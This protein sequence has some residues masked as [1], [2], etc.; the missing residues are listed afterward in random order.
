VSLGHGRPEYGG[1]GEG[2]GRGRWGKPLGTHQGSI[3]VLGW[4]WG[5]AGIGVLRRGRVAAARSSAPARWQLRGS[6]EQ[7]GEL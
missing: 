3:W 6:G 7:V 2:I 1:S 5:R 4:G